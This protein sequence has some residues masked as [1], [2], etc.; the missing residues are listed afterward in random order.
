MALGFVTFRTT[1][2]YSFF[3]GR[4]CLTCCQRR[5]WPWSVSKGT[6]HGRRITICSKDERD[7]TSRL[8]SYCTNQG[9]DRD[10]AARVITLAQCAARSWAS[11]MSE[12]LTPP[13]SVALG[14]AVETL[15]DV[16]ACPWGG[17]EDAERRA[18]FV[19]HAESVPSIEVL[20]QL[21]EEQLVLLKIQ[22]NF[23]TE[24]GKVL[25]P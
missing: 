6:N 23:E 3:P 4:R 17:Y 16:R 2:T 22:G 24:K 18:L 21:A 7:D 11:G 5:I 8:V 1:G 13:E 19:A 14:K 15:A 9:V 25:F 10:I 12:F 20:Q